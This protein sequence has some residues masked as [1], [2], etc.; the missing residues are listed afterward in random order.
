[1]AQAYHKHHYLS[2]AHFSAR[3]LPN[4]IHLLFSTSASIRGSRATNASFLA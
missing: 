1:L 4:V 3:H 2:N